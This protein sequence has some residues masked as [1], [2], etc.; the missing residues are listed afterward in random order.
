MK[1]VQILLLVLTAV[2][3]A[4]CSHTLKYSAGETLLDEDFSNE[5]AWEIYNDTGIELI[6]RDGVYNMSNDSRA[7]IWGVKTEA[8]Y[9]NIVMEATISPVSNMDDQAAALMCRT[10]GELSGF[11]YYFI[12]RNNGS[13]NIA[14]STEEGADFENLASGQS[15]AINEGGSNTVRIVC[16]DDYLALYVNDQFLAEANDTTY[17]EGLVALAVG[18]GT[19]GTAGQYTVDN[20]T[21][22]SAS[23]ASTEASE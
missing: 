22:E 15:S 9:D 20:L 6:T 10:E 21:I 13:Y 17:S 19:D 14:L 23:M 1:K 5:D 2:L 11:G 8:I 18:S 16:V 7:F 12:V 3:L 4:A